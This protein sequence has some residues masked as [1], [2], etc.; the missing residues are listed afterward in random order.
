MLLRPMMAELKL[1]EIGVHPNHGNTQNL[2]KHLLHPTNVFLKIDNP[3][4][5]SPNKFVGK[6]KISNYL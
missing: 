1:C 4:V 2:T 5:N 3:F 6:I